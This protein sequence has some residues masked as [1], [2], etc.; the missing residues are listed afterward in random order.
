ME[1]PAD[2]KHVRIDEQE[3]LRG[4]SISLFRGIVILEKLLNESFAIATTPHLS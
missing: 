3:K 4:A 1:K 2:V